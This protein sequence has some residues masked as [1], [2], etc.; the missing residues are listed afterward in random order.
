[1]KYVSKQVYILEE[2]IGYQE[3]SESD[4]RLVVQKEGKSAVVIFTG[5]WMGSASML[6]VIMEDLWT[7]Y[8]DKLYFFRVNLDKN[9]LA[10][11]FGILNTATVC[12]FA[13]VKSLTNR[14]VWYL[15]ANCE[16]RLINFCKP[17][18]NPVVLPV[19]VKTCNSRLN[20]SL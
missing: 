16:T 6:H 1:M 20:I 8:K 10:T 11:E 3:I 15:K 19:F 14:L 18:L 9:T 17:C 2:S 5:D 7:E 13:G 4:F 12:F